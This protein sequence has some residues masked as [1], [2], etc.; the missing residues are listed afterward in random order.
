MRAAVLFALPIEYAIPMS[1]FA[2]KT[3]RYAPDGVLLHPNVR[4]IKTFLF[5]YICHSQIG[6]IKVAFCIFENFIGKVFFMF[7]LRNKI[8]SF[9][10]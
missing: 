5:L 6:A 3:H 8:P 2:Y 1:V 7:L 4:R 9:F 10:F